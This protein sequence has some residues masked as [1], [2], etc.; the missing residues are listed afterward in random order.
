MKITTRLGLAFALLGG[1]MIGAVGYQLSV[2]QSVQQIN[3]EISLTSLDA[4]RISVRLLQGAEGVREFSAKYVATG[5]PGYRLQWEEWEASVEEDLISL[6][7]AELQGEASRERDAVLATWRDYRS[8]AGPLRSLTDE[9]GPEPPAGGGAMAAGFLPVTQI[10]PEALAALDETALALLDFRGHTETLIELNEAAVLAMRAETTRAADQARTI[11]WVAAGLALL[12]ALGTWL[13]LYLSI[14]DPLRRLTRGTREL[15]RGH[16]DHRLPVAGGTELSQL[17]RD[18]NEMAEQLGELEALKQD[19][20]SHVSHELKG[21]LA[22]IQE[23]ILV[24]LEELP[25]PITDRQRHLLEL[26]KESSGRL[27]TMIENLLEASRME[28]GGREY[29]PVRHDL[30]PIVRSVI[31]ESEPVS[32]ERALRVS[33]SLRSPE[34]ALICDGDRIR[35]V[36][37]NL[38]GNALKFS[39]RGGRIRITIGRCETPPAGVPERWQRALAR[40]RGPFLLLSVED[41]GPGVPEGHREAVFEK[42][43]QVRRGQRIQGQGVGLGLAI[44]RGVVE[45][46][47][48]AIWVEPAKQ[49]G[50]I[51]RVLL[52]ELPSRWETRD[53]EERDPQTQRAGTNAP[54]SP[55]IP[56]SR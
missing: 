2:V 38:I 49:G 22:A 41:D 16:F 3:Q 23:T 10:N 18:F 20:V 37:A 30:E 1:A 19:F 12:I 17:A 46:H 35:E 28:A 54:M 32:E 44:C 53:F 11:A 29:D 15:A 21:P 9:A 8:A 31:A 42:F 27:S 5:D 13:F 6:Q 34:T 47:R 33:L 43:H 39:P 45:A 40:E 26:S 4:A 56:G 36:A 7:R 50:A 48:G 51:F 55:S 24:F 14:S 25:G 52:P